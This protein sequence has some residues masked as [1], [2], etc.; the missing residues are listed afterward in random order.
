M[1]M[2]KERVKPL[3]VNVLYGK[4]KIKMS[5]NDFEVAKALGE[6]PR[7]WYLRETQGKPLYNVI[8]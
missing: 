5:L 8:C 3:K 4:W 6:L 2:E 7:S 1:K